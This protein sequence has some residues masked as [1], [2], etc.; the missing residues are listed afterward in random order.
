MR[1]VLEVRNLDKQVKASLTQK[2]DAADI[3]VKKI[4]GE[5]ASMSDPLGACSS[6][7]RTAYKKIISM[8][9][10]C[11]ANRVAAGIL[12]ERLLAKLA[13]EAEAVTKRVVR[14][15]GKP[16]RTSIRKTTRRRPGK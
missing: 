4:L 13:A 6:S 15:S 2:A 9:Y 3:R 14:N 11:S 12:V 7:E 5:K 8:I 10:E 1:K 16:S